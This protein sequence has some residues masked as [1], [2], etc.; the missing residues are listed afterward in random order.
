MDIFVILARAKAAFA[1]DLHLMAGAPPVVR[2]NGVLQPLPDLDPLSAQEVE[3]FLPRLASEA[4]RNRFAQSKEA[5]F[6]L[7][8]PAVGRSRVNA[9][10]QRGTVKLSIRFLPAK[11]PTIEGLGL[12]LILKDLA[13]REHGLFLVCGPSGAGKSHTL[14]AM[15]EHINENFT[16]SIVTIEDP[17][18]FVHENKRSIVIQRELGLDTLDLNEALRR[19]LRQDPDVIVVGE[20]RDRETISLALTAAETGHLVLSTVHASGAVEAISRIVDAFP[21]EAQPAVRSQVSLVL[22][23]ALYQALLS[24]ADGT[25]QVVA[26]EVLVTTSAIRNLIRE[27]KFAQIQSY[28][29]MGARTGMQTLEQAVEH[30][31]KQGLVG[32]AAALPFLRRE[33]A[34]APLSGA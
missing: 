11:P 25:G 29:E 8:V 5:D 34:E 30:L 7:T 17:I 26:C 21:L 16:R 22:L 27:G 33:G 32:P 4:V 12:P 9:C 18:E 3:G 13:S 28:L 31:R 10:L 1:S 24:K 15:V 6:A 19:A 2:V 20:M 23:G 14:A